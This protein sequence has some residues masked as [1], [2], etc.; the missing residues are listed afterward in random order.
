MW[1]T[2]HGN[3]FRR[4]ARGRAGRATGGRH[5][6]IV[7]F[8]FPERSPTVRRG[9]RG[10]CDPYHGACSAPS[11]ELQCIIPPFYAFAMEAANLE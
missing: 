8:R 1:G 6:S 10:T 4:R 3:A 2:P 11:Q 5:R 7:G 9:A